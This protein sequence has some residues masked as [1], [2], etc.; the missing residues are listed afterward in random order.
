MDLPL[1]SPNDYLTIIVNDDD[2][3]NLKEIIK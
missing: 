1:I 3:E 2:V